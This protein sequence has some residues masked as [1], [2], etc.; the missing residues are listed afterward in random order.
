VTKNVDYIYDA[1]N[2]L[3]RR[4]LDPDGATGSAALVDAIFSWD[5]GT[6]RR[7]GSRRA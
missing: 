3:I 1:F 6:A 5:S 4:T 7:A 2:R